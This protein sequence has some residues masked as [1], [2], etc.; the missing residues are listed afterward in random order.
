MPMVRWMA[1]A[2]ALCAAPAFAS[3]YAQCLI[4]SLAE[5]KSSAVHAA[6]V[7]MCGKKHPDG[8]FTL[9]R[10]TGRGLLGYKSADA[11]TVEKA[12]N[13]SWQHSAAIIRQACECLYGQPVTDTQMCVRYVLPA[14]VIEQHTDATT[15][16][17]RIAVEHHY[18]RIY[19][20][21]PDADT[22]FV[23]ADFLRWA[24]AAPQRQA[25][26]QSGKTGD[27]IALFTSYKAQLPDWER[28]VIT[29]PQR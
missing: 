14:G 5:S 1:A 18:R 4:D 9:Q 24:A 17:K 12:R 20:A 8:F 29:P 23:S 15:E 28:G 19:A 27:I 11:C 3:N 10:G 6:A 2:L 25:A 7:S 21:H 22:L 26:L 16:A 13:A